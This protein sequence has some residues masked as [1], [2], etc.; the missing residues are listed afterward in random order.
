MWVVVFSGGMEGGGGICGG[1][2]IGGHPIQGKSKG[3]GKGR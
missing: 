1:E 3:K 2:D